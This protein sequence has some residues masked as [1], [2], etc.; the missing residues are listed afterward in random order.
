MARS[1]PEFRISVQPNLGLSYKGFT[2]SAWGSQS[3]TN[4]DTAPQE[5]DINLSYNIKGFTVTI[6]DYWWEGMRAP[7]GYYADKH[8]FEGTIS[9]NFGEKFPLTLS[10]STMFAGG[11]E[12]KKG[13]RAFSTYIYAAYDIAC[14]MD[15]TLTPSVGFTPWKGM[16]NPDNAAFTDIS[17]KASKSIT[18]TDKFSIPLFVQ[19]TVA[20]AADKVYLLAGFSLGF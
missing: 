3:I 5:Y 20:P 16:Y 6:T 12:N 1:L 19:T 10:W 8:H 14:P 15:I 17:L 2:L 4:S 9:Y 13:N 7:Y 18:V 11:D